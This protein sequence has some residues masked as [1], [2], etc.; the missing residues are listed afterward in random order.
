MKTRVT[1]HDRQSEGT[2]AS[3]TGIHSKNVELREWAT[4]GRRDIDAGPLTRTPHVEQRL[5]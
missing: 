2:P 5:R 3:T 1:S 4:Y